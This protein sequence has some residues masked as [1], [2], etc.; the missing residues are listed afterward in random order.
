MISVPSSDIYLEDHLFRM[1]CRMQPEERFEEKSLRVAIKGFI[2]EFGPEYIRH[3][4]KTS[5]I[6]KVVQSGN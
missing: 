3:L 1:V 4:E 2:E 6:S 5:D